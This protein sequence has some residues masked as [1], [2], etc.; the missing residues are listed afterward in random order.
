MVTLRATVDTQ[1]EGQG[2]LILDPNRR[3]FNEFG[4]VGGASDMKLIELACALKYIKTDKGPPV[5]PLPPPDG[6]PRQR[7]LYKLEGKSITSRLSLVAADNAFSSA[8]LLVHDKD[9][10]VASRTVQIN[11]LEDEVKKLLK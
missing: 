7:K 8:R 2:T 9:G 5:P 1:G 4:D 3:T 10:K 6:P 11:D